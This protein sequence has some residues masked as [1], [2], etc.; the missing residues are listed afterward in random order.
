MR[1]L[2]WL[3]FAI[4]VYVYFGYPLLLAVRRR[5]EGK[6]VR[7][8]HYEPA[9]TL[10]IAAHNER[11][12]IDRKIQNCF[13][14]DYPKGKL[15]IIVTL[16]GPT[17]GTEFAVWKY[18]RQGVQMVHNKEHRGKPSAL[19]AGMRRATGDVVVFADARQMFAPDAI[20]RLVENFADDRIGG[21]SGELILVDTNEAE[22]KSEVGLYWKYEKWIRS[23]ESDLHSV[24][25]ATGAIY[26]IRRE[27]YRDL[28]EDTLL[29]DVS[30]PMNI[31]FSGR[32]VVFEPAAKAYDAVSCCARAE[33][34]R[35]VR[36]LAGNYQLLAQM[37]QLLIPWRNP[38]FWQ[39]CSH[40]LGRLV[41]PHLLIVMLATNLMAMG[42]VYSWL[43]AAQCAWYACAAAGHFA[44]K[45]NVVITPTVV[46][47]EQQRRAA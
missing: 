40:K 13:E 45:R 47:V 11:E 9:V 44:A 26:A 34:G 7:K 35:K 19:N 31:V 22:A 3:S 46:N 12:R 20:R 41:V 43:F 15:Q 30:T 14:L 29:D 18:A 24:A 6:P 42:G 21:V 16:D 2:F 27:L 32:R 33:F 36:T 10:L 37:P 38:I 39:F 28:P 8:A 25:G 5:L 17:D 4:V 23:M 1:I